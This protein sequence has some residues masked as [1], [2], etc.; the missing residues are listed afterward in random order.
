MTTLNL[1]TG[2][3]DQDNTFPIL[4]KTTRNTR[5]ITASLQQ[6][7]QKLDDGIYWALQSAVCIKKEYTDKDRAETVR[8]L[9]M[10]I[11][12]HNDIVTINKTDY[13]VKVLGDSSDC[14]IFEKL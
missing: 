1:S 13:R 14:A 11:I 6:G 9:K 12:K 8:L 3:F 7:Y 4:V 5:T 2:S 10:P